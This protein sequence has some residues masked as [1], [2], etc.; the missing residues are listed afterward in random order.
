MVKGKRKV[1]SNPE[2]EPQG[3]VI[4]APATWYAY[5]WPPPAD[6][7]R[8]ETIYRNFPLVSAA[9]E[10][11]AEQALSAYH[12]EGG[13]ESDVKLLTEF[14][15]K[16]R[17]KLKI[18]RSFREVMTY[19]NCFWEL[20][21]DS[22]EKDPKNDFV[23]TSLGNLVDVQVMPITTMR[24][25]PDP[26]TGADPAYGYVQII[27]GKTVKFAPEQIAHF[28]FNDTGGQVG[29]DFYGMG[30]IQSS[31]E[32]IDAIKTMQSFMVRIM[33]R[34]AAPRNLWN[35]GDPSKPLPSPEA[36]EA[37]EGKLENLGPDEDIVADYMLKAGSI[38]PEVKARFEEYVNHIF[39]NIV[40]GMQNPNVVL[41]TANIR[42]SDASANAMLE[43]LGRKVALVQAGFSENLE[44]KVF[45]P[46]LNKDETPHM[47]WG[48][49]ATIDPVKEFQSLVAILANQSITPETRFDV[50]N[51]VRRLLE[52][53]PL[54]ERTLP[55]IPPDAIQALGQKGEEKKAGDK[56]EK[57]EESIQVRRMTLLSNYN[58]L[59]E[60]EL[61][62][63]GLFHE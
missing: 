34:Y 59:A 33:K 60:A 52:L 44:E 3:F 14:M 19:G 18:L 47:V 29:S 6:W 9:I 12:L 38:G 48:K 5:G 35:Y 1:S 54:T 36:I 31:T 7:L 16:K 20:R 37:I 10:T 53:E 24:V 32:Y 45:R 41:S 30:L 28:K 39:F 49:V 17:M 25:V 13:D 8:I 26:H 57:L 11:L 50:E 43:N 22:I 27:Y 46:F 62:R 58:K 42:V 15:D 40:L 61:R 2:G 21:Y 55:V 56:K 63:K 23:V 51:K 4:G